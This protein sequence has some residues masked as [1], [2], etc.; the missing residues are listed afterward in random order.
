MKTITV[1]GNPSETTVN[2]T[3]QTGPSAASG[4]H[5]ELLV[6]LQNAAASLTKLVELELTGVCDGQG[7]WIGS[8]P[9]LDTTRKLVN[10]AEQRVSEFRR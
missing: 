2:L 5:A 1:V 7:F 6:D 4:R 9:L 10:I 3:K 8:D